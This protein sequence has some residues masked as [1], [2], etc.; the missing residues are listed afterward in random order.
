MFAAY[1]AYD[2]INIAKRQNEIADR[3]SLG[4]LVADITQQKRVLEKTTPAER[5]PFEQA[6][7]ADAEE[8]LALVDTLSKPVPPIDNYEIGTAFEGAAAYYNALASYRRAAETSIDPHYRASSLRGEAKIFYALGGAANLAKA[9]A[10]VEGAY[11]SYDGQPDVSRTTL[12]SNFIF[13]DLF[14]ARN[15]APSDCE[16]ARTLLDD[17]RSLARAY[18][19]AVSTTAKGMQGYA[20]EVVAR[21]P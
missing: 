7:Q 13:T 9:R 10:A 14:A 3:Q 17:G 4:A 20:E 2:Q 21:C 15:E 11:H 16:H 12:E 18:P 19:N 6:V 5:L 1:G 8:A